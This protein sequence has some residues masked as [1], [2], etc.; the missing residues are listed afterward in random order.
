M[1]RG[2]PNRAGSELWSLMMLLVQGQVQ[3][4]RSYVRWR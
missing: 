3:H 4:L 1:V 2:T